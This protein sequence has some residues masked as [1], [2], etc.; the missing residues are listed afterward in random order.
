MRQNEIFEMDCGDTTLLIECV[1]ANL[2]SQ[3]SGTI[4]SGIGA[5]VIKKLPKDLFFEIGC[6]ANN[7]SNEFRKNLETLD[8]V[9]KEVE[10]E[11]GF[12]VTTTGKILVLSAETEIGMK[13]K[14]KWKT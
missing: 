3:S 11:F 5:N 6:L 4:P 12:G 8:N 2:P 10:L 9:P 13:L 7:V 14:L 1:D